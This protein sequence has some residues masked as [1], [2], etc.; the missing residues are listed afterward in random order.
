MTP[1]KAAHAGVI[2]IDPAKYDRKKTPLCFK[3]F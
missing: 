2:I 1:A 3:D